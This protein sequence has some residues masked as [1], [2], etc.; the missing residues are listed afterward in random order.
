M[1][2]QRNFASKTR[3]SVHNGTKNSVN[4]KLVGLRT[5]EKCKLVGFSCLNQLLKLLLAPSASPLRCQTENL[6]KD[7]SWKRY[8]LNLDNAETSLLSLSAF[9]LRLF[10]L[11][12]APVGPQ[13]FELLLAESPALTQRILEERSGYLP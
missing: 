4:I 13:F 3:V 7:S 1:T 8:I 10:F 5:T 12:C 9:R 2:W 11:L 6:S